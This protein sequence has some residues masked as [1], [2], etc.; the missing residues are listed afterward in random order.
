M[1]GNRDSVHHHNAVI[2]DFED[3]GQVSLTLAGTDTDALV[4][5]D[6]HLATLPSYVDRPA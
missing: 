4:N 6:S 1:C 5:L 3:V 2:P